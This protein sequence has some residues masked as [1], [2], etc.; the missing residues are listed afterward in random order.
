MKVTNT[1]FSYGVFAI[2]RN[3]K[4][5]QHGFGHPSAEEKV[6]VGAEYAVTNSL[7]DNQKY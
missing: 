6:E 7:H 4:K 3:M 1:P 5:L 2:P